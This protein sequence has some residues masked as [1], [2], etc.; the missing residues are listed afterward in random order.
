MGEEGKHLSKQT[1]NNKSQKKPLLMASKLNYKKMQGEVGFKMLLPC[2]Q[3]QN[4][5]K[6]K[7][8]THT[9]KK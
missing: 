8:K 4:N 2:L 5:I 9:Q 3:N 7:Q 6:K 1:Q